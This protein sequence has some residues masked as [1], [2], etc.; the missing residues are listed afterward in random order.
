MTASP[1]QPSLNAELTRALKILAGAGQDGLTEATLF[2]YGFW[3]E[4]LAELVLA[5][6]AT[7]KAE[8]IGPAI[9]VERYRV[10]AAGRRAIA[11][12]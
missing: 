2:A 3:P 4:M 6:L 8:T 11:A 1:E 7:V 12:E 10:T 5:K 9:K